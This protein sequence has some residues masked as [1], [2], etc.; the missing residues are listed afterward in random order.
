MTKI[1]YIPSGE[2]IQF[3]KRDDMSV[4]LTW[5]EIFE[6][7]D[8]TWYSDTNTPEKYIEKVINKNYSSFLKK[9]VGKIQHIRAEF[10]IIY[11]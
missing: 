2:Y 7:S 1:L 4:D 9:R 6:K 8:N 3:V 11:D 10:E 5:T